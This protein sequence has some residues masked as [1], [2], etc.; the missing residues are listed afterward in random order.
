LVKEN[1]DPFLCLYILQNLGH[2]VPPES[3]Y[4]VHIQQ[5]RVKIYLAQLGARSPWGRKVAQNQRNTPAYLYGGDL[6]WAQ[7][8]EYMGAMQ[9]QFMRDVEKL[10]AIV[11]RLVSEWA[12][13][14]KDSIAKKF[15]DPDPFIRWVAVHTA[16]KRW[17]PLE[18]ELI[19]LLADKDAAVRDAARHTLVRLSRGNDFGPLLKATPGQMEHAQNQWN[20]WL[21]YQFNRGQK[22]T[23]AN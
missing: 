15:R 21:A 20:Q 11:L 12:S 18:K 2:G 13:E 3:P 9:A 16:G 22:E 23:H 10:D 17:M 6:L 4:F 7:Q 8:V 19:E 1:G 14:G 5:L